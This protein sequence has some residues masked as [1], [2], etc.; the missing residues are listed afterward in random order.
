VWS[1]TEAPACA[2][3]G[4]GEP[5]VPLDDPVAV[6]VDAPWRFAA[7]RRFAALRPFAALRALEG[8]R[9]FPL[10]APRAF[11]DR[12]ARASSQRARHARVIRRY[13]EPRGG[14]PGGTRRGH[15]VDLAAALAFGAGRRGAGRAVPGR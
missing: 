8:P 15:D 1:S 10:D 12:H 7:P 9:T 2:F 3:P 13:A 11:R 4:A 14:F 5:R 6:A